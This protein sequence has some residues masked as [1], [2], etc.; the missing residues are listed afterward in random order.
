MLELVDGHWAEISN[1]LPELESMFEGTFIQKQKV[2]YLISK[3]YYHL[4]EYD[5]SVDY[6]LDSGDLFDIK[7]KNIYV[8]CVISQGLNNYVK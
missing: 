7:T 6:A 2:A 5:E 4:E 3:L 8:E 1:K